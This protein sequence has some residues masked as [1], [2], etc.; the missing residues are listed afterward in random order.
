MPDHDAAAMTDAELRVL[1]E[2]LGMTGDALAAY[3]D[4]SDR[5]VRHWEAGKYAIPAGVATTVR[6]LAADTRDAVD[7]LAAQLLTHP[8][9]AAVVYRTDAEYWAA[10]PTAQ[11][12]ASW[13]RA[14]VG[15]V[16]E[17]VDGLEVTYPEWPERM[18]E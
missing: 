6:A 5:T 3:L 14:V 10:E 18:V 13:Q 12:P 9:P 16:R 11:L 15:R 17:L 4:V 8:E 2:H 7:E 1:R